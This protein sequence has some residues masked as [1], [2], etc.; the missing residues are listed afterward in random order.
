[1]AQE[2]IQLPVPRGRNRDTAEKAKEFHEMRK[3]AIEE[4]YA[5]LLQ[6]AQRECE[7]AEYEFE[8][9][10]AKL[11]RLPLHWKRS[12]A[13]LY[14]PLLVLLAIAEIPVNMMQ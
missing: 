4:Q 2:P 12:R 6:N 3:Q 9:L 11:N 8:A 10:R 5:P 1:M 13:R 7:E 14:L